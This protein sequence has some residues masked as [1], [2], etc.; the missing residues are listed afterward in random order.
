MIANDDPFTKIFLNVVFGVYLFC[1]FLGAAFVSDEFDAEK[2]FL[3]GLFGIPMATLFYF[4]SWLYPQWPKRFVI[5]YRTMIFS[6]FL[7]YLTGN[8]TLL[9]AIGGSTKEVSHRTTIL[10]EEFVSLKK[11]G[12]FGFLYKYRF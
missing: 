8:L 4:F 1:G 2:A 3:F 10:T 11:V 9:N 7:I 12:A 5:T 6:L